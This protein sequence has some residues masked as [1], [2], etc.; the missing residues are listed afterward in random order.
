MTLHMPVLPKTI[1]LVPDV[2]EFSRLRNLPLI[3]T[4]S[5]RVFSRE[6][7]AYLKRFNKID[8]VYVF[9]IKR[10]SHEVCHAFP[11]SIVF[12]SFQWAYNYFRFWLPVFFR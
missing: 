2:H 8:L 3:L 6:Q 4:Y 5:K 11:F 9:S 10:V 7:I 1:D 12:D